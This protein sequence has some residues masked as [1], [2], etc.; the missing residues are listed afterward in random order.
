M[1]KVIAQ[2]GYQVVAHGEGYTVLLPLLPGHG[3][4]NPNEAIEGRTYQQWRDVV[5]VVP[6]HRSTL[7]NQVSIGGFSTWRG[8]L[9]GCSIE[10]GSMRPGLATNWRGRSRS[11]GLNSY[12]VL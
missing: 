5:D 2:A 12:L 1:A 3:R 9:T 8:R 10:G 7:A 4:T 6:S 11:A